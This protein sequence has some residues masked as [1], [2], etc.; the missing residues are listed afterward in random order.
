MKNKV[1]MDKLIKLLKEKKD[2]G[3][4]NSDIYK[5]GAKTSTKMVEKTEVV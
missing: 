1:N 2:Q 5:F 3:I 4:L